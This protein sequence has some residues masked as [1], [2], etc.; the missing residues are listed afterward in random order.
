MKK[1]VT[2]GMSNDTQ[3]FIIFLAGQIVMGL[4]YQY[5]F[6]P[7]EIERRA[8]EYGLMQYDSKQD[9]MIVRDSAEFDNYTLQYLQYG[10]TNK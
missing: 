7:M 4:M 10:K 1:R 2:K 5:K 6:M 8:N 9:K 3:F